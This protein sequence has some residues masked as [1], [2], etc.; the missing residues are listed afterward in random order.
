MLGRQFLYKGWLLIILRIELRHE[1][2]LQ[3]IS[4]KYIVLVMDLSGTEPSTQR[5]KSEKGEKA[6][7][8]SELKLLVTPIRVMDIQLC[9]V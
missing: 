8:E 1:S 5:S 7:V 3:R 6:E 4:A 2:G 9:K